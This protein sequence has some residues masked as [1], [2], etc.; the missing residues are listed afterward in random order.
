M[1]VGHG[2]FRGADPPLALL[3]PDR[4]GDERLPINKG[5]IAS[6][7]SESFHPLR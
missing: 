3:A 4:L 7:L 6:Y 1:H 5:E 2:I